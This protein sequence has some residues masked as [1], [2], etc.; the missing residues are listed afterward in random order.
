[1]RRSI[2]GFTLIELLVTI[3]IIG[4]LASVGLVVYSSTQKSARIS[5]RLQDLQA[6]QSAVETYKAATGTYPKVAAANVCVGAGTGLAAASP[7][8]TPN[9]MQTL[10]GDPSGS[11]N[12][13][14]Y[15]S[16][17]NGTEY[18]I[19]TFNTEMTDTEY[20]AQPNYIDP[21]RDSGTADCAVESGAVSAWAIYS[22][23]GTADTNACA[24]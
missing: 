10:P 17:A 16:D 13:Y 14:K 20:R 23:A 8:F 2:V 12:C 19:W 5:K 9:Y 22:S 1:M 4:I 3:T 15:Q 21:K 18:K 6:I 24:F 11:S 7:A